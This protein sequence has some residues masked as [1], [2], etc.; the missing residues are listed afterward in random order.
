MI[1]WKLTANTV[2][3]ISFNSRALHWKR[4][5][6]DW[7]RVRKRGRNDSKYRETHLNSNREIGKI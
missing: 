2:I 1:A 7:K 5:D 6:W 4:N 3:W